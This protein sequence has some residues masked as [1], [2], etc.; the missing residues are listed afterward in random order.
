M[1]DIGNKLSFENRKLSGITNCTVE[2]F[3]DRVDKT[4]LEEKL[5]VKLELGVLKN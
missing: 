2:L 5:G 4:V 1:A 3:R